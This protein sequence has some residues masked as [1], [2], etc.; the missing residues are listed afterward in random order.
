MRRARSSE[1]IVFSLSLIF[2]S[3]FYGFCAAGLDLFPAP[4]FRRVMIQAAVVMRPPHYAVPI[5]HPR[6][7]ARTLSSGARQPGPTPITSVWEDLDWAPG[8]KLVDAE[9]RVLH[10]WHVPADSLFPPARN[11]RNPMAS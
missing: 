1:R 10:S 6:H 9:G 11:I 8:L 2:V 7:G 5:V 3:V 4:F